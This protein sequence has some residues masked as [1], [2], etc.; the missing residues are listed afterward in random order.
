M[1]KKFA[2]PR[3]YFGNVPLNCG[4]ADLDHQFNRVWSGN[5]FIGIGK[6][7]EIA[8]LRVLMDLYSLPNLYEQIL[9][10]APCR[11]CDLRIKNLCTPEICV[12]ALHDLYGDAVL[13]NGIFY[14][15]DIDTRVFIVP[16]AAQGSLRLPLEIVG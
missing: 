15:S 16:I 10:S 12:P 6:V 13:R 9:L 8:N 1:S 14:P 4:L 2:L 5:R 11:D 7:I 3:I